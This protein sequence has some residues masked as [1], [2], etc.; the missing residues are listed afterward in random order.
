MSKLKVTITI[1]PAL[2]SFLA[3]VCDRALTSQIRSETR[4]WRR[5]DRSKVISALL[6]AIRESGI[7]FY[8]A[9]TP[10]ELKAAVKRRLRGA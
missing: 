2:D 1:D 10:E 4:G 6:D 5:M 9:R 3:E 7:D 8:Q